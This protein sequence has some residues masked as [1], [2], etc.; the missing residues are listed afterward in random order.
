MDK[1]SENE[2][3]G[4]GAIS[5]DW[6]WVGLCEWRVRCRGDCE[7]EKKRRN[8]NGR[9]GSNNSVCQVCVSVQKR[10]YSNRGPAPALTALVPLL[11]CCAMAE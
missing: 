9:E 7:E 5:A 2:G 10:R 4:W 6:T 11:L 3:G 8:I 1:R